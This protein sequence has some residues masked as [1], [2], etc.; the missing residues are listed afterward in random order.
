[1][2]YSLSMDD[3]P[4]PLCCSCKSYS[5]NGTCSAFPR[6]I[7][8]EF[9]GNLN[10]HTEVH[11]QQVG[12]N[13]FELE[14][15]EEQWGEGTKVVNPMPLVPLVA[16]I[17]HSSAE[18]P[19]WYANSY[20]ISESELEKELVALTDWY[21]RELFGSVAKL[22]GAI[23]EST[24][25]RFVVDCERFEEDTQEIMASQGMGVIYTHGTKQQRIRETP[26]HEEREAL[27]KKFY[28][29]HHA[30]LT[31]LTEYC[32][33]KFGR[34]LVIDCH[35]YPATPLPYELYADGRRPDMCFGTDPTHT[36]SELLEALSEFSHFADRTTDQD[37]PFKGTL[38]PLK[39]YGDT[40]LTGVMFELNR[41]CYL[42][43][44]SSEKSA[45]FDSTKNWMDGLIKL[46]V[47]YIQAQL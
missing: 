7:P 4:E 24:V 18:I 29:P 41:S 6:A 34:C 12:E 10:L 38:L 46:C 5:G 13:I 25:S 30:A 2:S 20:S 11:P 33:N 1:M 23:V 27:L 22:G 35:S 31:E 9:L 37:T 14:P 26:S 16:H 45:G 43:G 42:V 8:G 28:R 3:F 44:T 39:F 36:P 40:R 17:P 21:T 15:V 32:L 47:E 19:R